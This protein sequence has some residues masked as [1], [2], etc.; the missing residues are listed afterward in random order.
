MFQK[1]RAQRN[2]NQ[3]TSAVSSLTTE[4]KSKSGG[5]KG[6]GD[7]GCVLCGATRHTVYRCDKIAEMVFEAQQ[8]A[9]L[10]VAP[11]PGIMVKINGRYYEG[12]LDSGNTFRS[13]ISKEL[14]D[15]L[16]ERLRQLTT[17]DTETATTADATPLNILGCLKHPL[18]ISIKGA[19][20]TFY[21]NLCRPYLLG[22][23]HW[24]GFFVSV[25][26]PASGC[27][28]RGLSSRTG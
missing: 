24:L 3:I 27:K 19:S 23:S 6:G 14:Y 22:R 7:K 10:E 28:W 8:A 11:R 13:C 21:V 12:I 26:P 18:P 5:G 17:D 25:P 15:S 1:R 16:P 4:P 20:R 2:I 9:G